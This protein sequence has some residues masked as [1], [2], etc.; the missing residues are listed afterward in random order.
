MPVVKESITVT[1]TIEDGELMRW[2]GKGVGWTEADE[3]YFHEGDDVAEW[4]EMDPD[5]K[6]LMDQGT[7]FSIVFHDVVIDYE[8]PIDDAY[9][10]DPGGAWLV[11]NGK[12]EIVEVEHA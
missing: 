8:S 2:E 5:I 6:Q 9:G 12:H 10:S 3:G 7:T 1:A 4:I 11:C